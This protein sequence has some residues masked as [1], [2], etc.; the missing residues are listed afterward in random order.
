MSREDQGQGFVLR[1][2][3]ILG[4]IPRG[5]KID[6]Y[7]VA[8]VREEVRVLWNF[9][10]L[11]LPNVLVIA[12]IEGF[13]IVQVWDKNVGSKKDLPLCMPHC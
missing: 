5:G 9:K 6:F 2:L 13:N 4:I 7:H 3:G 10:I 8:L 1:R 12:K 11:V